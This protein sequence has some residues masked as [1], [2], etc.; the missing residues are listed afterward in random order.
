MLGFDLSIEG[1]TIHDEKF[2]DFMYY[3]MPKLP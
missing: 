2:L 3:Q 1:R